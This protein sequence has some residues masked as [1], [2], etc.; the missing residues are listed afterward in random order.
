MGIS[1][2]RMFDT[3]KGLDLSST[4]L[5][6]YEDA[7]RC[8][9]LIELEGFVPLSDPRIER[10]RSRLGQAL[11]RLLPFGGYAVPLTPPRPTRP[12]LRRAAQA[13]RTA[14]AVGAE[15]PNP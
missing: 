13:E 2:H 14:G 12:T 1:R 8:Y 3:L 4:F 10:F 6:S 7:E 15:I 5:A 9:H 11:H